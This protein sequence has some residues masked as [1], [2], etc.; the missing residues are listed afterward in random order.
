[1]TRD[2]VCLLLAGAPRVATAR[3]KL[4]IKLVMKPVPPVKNAEYKLTLDSNKPPAN[5]NEV[6]PG[7][8]VV[9]KDSD[10]IQCNQKQFL[11]MCI[12]GVFEQLVFVILCWLMCVT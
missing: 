9:L 6:F 1:M 11:D 4:P 2:P 3:A 10:V 5:L 8:I 7:L 12:I